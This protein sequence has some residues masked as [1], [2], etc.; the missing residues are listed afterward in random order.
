MFWLMHDS[1][2]H[3]YYF[4]GAIACQI[5][6]Q[7]MMTE[8]IKTEDQNDLKGEVEIERIPTED[9]EMIRSS[10]CCFLARNLKEKIT[11]SIN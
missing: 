9:I 10:F 5:Y 7:S 6:F 4:V 3:Y 11:T 8:G 1:S 2:Y